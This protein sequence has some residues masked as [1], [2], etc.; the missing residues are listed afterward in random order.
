MSEQFE[1]LEVNAS[2]ARKNNSTISDGQPLLAAIYGGISG[3]ESLSCSFP[4]TLA[5]WREKE[6]I[7]VKWINKYPT[8]VTAQV[9]YAGYYIQLGWFHRG[10]GYSNTVSKESRMLFNENIEKARVLLE[11]HPGKTK[12]DAGWYLAM[13]GVAL[14]QGWSEEKFNEIYNEAVKFHSTYI[15]LYFLKASYMEPKWHGSL[16]KFNDYVGSVVKNTKPALGNQ[17][18]ARLH[19]SG[20]GKNLFKSGRTDWNK[21]KQSFEELVAKYPDPWN[22]NNYAKFACLAEDYSKLSELLAVIGNNT[23]SAAWYNDSN[24]Y[25]TCYDFSLNK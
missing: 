5:E 14:Y 16:L 15:P 19:W 11:S 12:K 9:G 23:L 1:E 25:F 8:S 24:F 22:V 4:K 7:L 20:S 21:M 18:Y 10:G 13:L 6:K 2:D 3:C 17:M